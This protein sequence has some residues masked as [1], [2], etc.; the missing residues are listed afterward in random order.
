[1]VKLI[2]DHSWILHRKL[3]RNITYRT[4]NGGQMK[5]RYAGRCVSMRAI[6]DKLIIP[7]RITTSELAK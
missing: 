1:M 7:M 5:V 4:L 2:G 3:M 6:I